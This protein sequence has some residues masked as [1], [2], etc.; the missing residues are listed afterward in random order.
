[1]EVDR[2]QQNHSLF[3]IGLLSLILCLTMLAISLYLLPHLLLGW[4]YDV[5]E[6][7]SHFRQWLTIQ[8][9]LSAAGASKMIFFSFLSSAI[10]LGI[11]A[12]IASS[13][14]ENQIYANEFPDTQSE[15]EYEMSTAPKKEVMKDSLPTYLNVLGIIFLA[16]AAAFFVHWFISTPL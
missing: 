5:P 2:Y 10:G 12:Y 8:F 1:M 9:A 16:V 7:I 6:F 3:I 13:R 15:P 4:R 11:I 14:I